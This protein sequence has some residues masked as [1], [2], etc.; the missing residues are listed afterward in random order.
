MSVISLLIFCD[1][2]FVNVLIGV[3]NHAGYWLLLIE[4]HHNSG[5]DPEIL[6]PV[7]YYIIYYTLFTTHNY[8]EFI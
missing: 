7:Y 3:I 1:V 5:A 6:I 8:S 4:W 2:I